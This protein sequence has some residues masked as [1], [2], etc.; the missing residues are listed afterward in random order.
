MF[1]HKNHFWII[2]LIL[3]I[4][5]FCLGSR[6]WDMLLWD[7]PNIEL[8]CQS[9]HTIQCFWPLTAFISMEVKNNYFH[10]TMQGILNKI[11]Q[12]KFSLGC[13]VWLFQL[14]LSVEILIRCFYWLSKPVFNIKNH[15]N[16]WKIISWGEHFMPF[17]AIF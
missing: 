12:I 8:E 14:R 4:K 6:I 16:H 13:K 1:L 15:S 7:E 9:A 2:F 5:I 10:V 17:F 11:S 3:E